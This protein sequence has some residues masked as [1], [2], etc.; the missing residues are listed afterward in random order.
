MLFTIPL[1]TRVF[2]YEII[3]LEDEANRRYAKYLQKSQHRIETFIDQT[4]IYNP[5]PLIPLADTYL[6]HPNHSNHFSLSPCALSFERP[7]FIAILTRWFE[8]AKLI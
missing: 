3:N 8:F 2:G 7:F 6:P 5:T 4:I 1:L